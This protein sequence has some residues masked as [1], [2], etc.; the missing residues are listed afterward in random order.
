MAIARGA[1]RRQGERRAT[2]R[3]QRS[4]G[5]PDGVERRLSLRRTSNRRAGDDRREG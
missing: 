5:A 1:P 2:D 4:D 3:R